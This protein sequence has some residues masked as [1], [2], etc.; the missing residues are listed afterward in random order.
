MK[1]TAFFLALCLTVLALASCG[2]P[3]G[4]NSGDDPLNKGD[5]SGQYT[6]ASCLTS[7]DDVYILTLP[8][9]GQKIKLGSEM[10]RFI[11]FITDEL[12]EAAEKKIAE[13]TSKYDNNSGFYLQINDDCLCLA[14]EVIRYFD[15]SIVPDGDVEDHEH[16]FFFERISDRAVVETNAIP[17]AVKQRSGVIY[18]SGENKISAM[19]CILAADWDNGDD[20]NGGIIIDKIAIEDV[21]NG[22]YEG[23]SDIPTLEQNGTVEADV[24]FNGD[25]ENVV[26]FKSNGKEYVRSDIEFDELSMLEAGTYYVAV[27]VHIYGGGCE[28]DDD[29]PSFSARYED[30]FRLLV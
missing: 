8:Q 22:K 21:I 6:V 16:L 27:I 24:P 9:C 25:I 20:T 10:N 17:S 1:K 5:T 7:E 28:D 2:K 13:D 4:A 19:S 18:R 30:V 14:A 26:L 29:T 12:V 23:L 15:E 11:P 3:Y